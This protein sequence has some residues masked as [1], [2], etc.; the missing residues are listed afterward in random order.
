M[1][2]LSKGTDFSTGDQVTAAKL[3]A[4]VDNATFASDA[5]DGSTTA[6]DTNGKIIVKDG[7]ITTAKLDLSGNVNIGNS[8]L[9]VSS[10]LNTFQVSSENR[11]FYVDDSGL[12]NYAQC[13]FRQTDD[14]PAFGFITGNDI[15]FKTGTTDSG[16]SSIMHLDHD[17]KVGIGTDS[18]SE[19]LHVSGTTGD[20]SIKLENTSTGTSDDTIYR[21][22]IGG[23]TARNFIYFGDADDDNRGEISYYH[24]GDSMRFHT[25][26]VEQARIINNGILIGRTSSSSSSEQEGIVLSGSGFIYLARSGTG[27]QTHAQFINNADVSAVAVGTIK[28]SGSATSYNTSSDYRL[29]EDIVEMQ[30]SISK[31]QS[32]KPVNFAWKVDGTRVDGFLAHEAQEVVPAAVTG[33]K[34][35]VDED[36]QPDYQGI[37]QS[38]IVPLLTKALQ[39]ALTKIESLEARVA[40]LES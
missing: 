16:L 28:T 27:T 39:E 19:E 3:D 1:A 6:L 14:E 30:D 38:K 17:G 29:K 37:D 22:Q 34:D 12:T 24:D 40:A 20:P 23:T 32:L 18:P 2:I 13:G 36:G 31:V 15:T 33:T 9:D 10:P 26:A 25:S 21:S 7:G 11:L 4:L 8:T 5:V 35:A